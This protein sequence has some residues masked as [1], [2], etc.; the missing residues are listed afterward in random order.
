MIQQIE[1][2]GQLKNADGRNANGTQHMFTLAIL[3]KIKEERLK[4][5]HGSIT[6][7]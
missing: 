2:I 5:S 1:F 3:E 4:F 6:V 7:L